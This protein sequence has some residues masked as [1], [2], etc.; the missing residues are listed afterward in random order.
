MARPETGADSEEGE[1]GE[2]GEEKTEKTGQKKHLARLPGEGG[3]A[4]L[5][6]LS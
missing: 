2:K 6:L 5:C 4:F 3:A 1:A